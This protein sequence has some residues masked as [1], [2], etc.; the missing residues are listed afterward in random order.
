[1]AGIGQLL[2][3]L[4]R[5]GRVANELSR[6]AQA[7]RGL[8]F[9]ETAR[10]AQALRGYRETA[11]N[12]WLKGIRRP[13]PLNPARDIIQDNDNDKRKKRLLTRSE[14]FHRHFN[15]KQARQNP[16]YREVVNVENKSRF[17]DVKGLKIAY[18]N[19]N[20]MFYD[21]GTLYVTGTGGKSG[22][23]SKVNDVFSDIFLNTYKKFTVFRKI[24]RCKKRD[25]QKPRYN[26][27]SWT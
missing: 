4:A 10:T 2:Q 15:N 22:L 1:M 14:D 13:Q 19:K 9:D 17:D 3:G 24:P 26:T 18:D 23:G 25:R 6:E 21:N 7:L 27:L 5:T 8:E 12:D 11:N 20:G 16:K